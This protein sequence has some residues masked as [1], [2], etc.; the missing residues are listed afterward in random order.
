[1]N[2]YMA[3]LIEDLYAQCTYAHYLP[4]QAGSSNHRLIVGG[5]DITAV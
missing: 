5:R 4:N 2:E 1:M 3:C